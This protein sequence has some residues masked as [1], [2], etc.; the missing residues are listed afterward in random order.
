MPS[1]HE[2]RDRDSSTS[3]SGGNRHVPQDQPH[4]AN[5]L[6]GLGVVLPFFGSQPKSN[7]RN[8]PDAQAMD[9][10]PG[11]LHTNHLIKG[12]GHFALLLSKTVM[13]FAARHPAPLIHIARFLGLSCS[14]HGVAGLQLK[15]QCYNDSRILWPLFISDGAERRNPT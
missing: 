6:L 3:C 11:S 14:S 12:K 9:R 1:R 4:K 15:D 13:R 5:H 10:P 2:T 8:V 7:R